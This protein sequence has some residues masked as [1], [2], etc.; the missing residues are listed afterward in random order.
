MELG[1]WKII[2]GAKYRE[3]IFIYP[4]VLFNVFK[5]NIDDMLL[6]CQKQMAQSH[7]PLFH[8]IN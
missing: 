2:I 6:T 7:S 5:V 3:R 4:K 8:L 1:S